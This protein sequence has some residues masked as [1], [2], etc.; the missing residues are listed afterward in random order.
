MLIGLL[1]LLSSLGAHAA[2][3]WTATC[4]TRDDPSVW[5]V[6]AAAPLPP[7]APPLASDFDCMGLFFD[8]TVACP[9]TVGLGKI[10]PGDTSPGG[11]PLLELRYLP[12]GDS[13]GI[14]R[15]LS[16]PQGGVLYKLPTIAAPTSYAATPPPSTASQL[17]ELYLNQRN[18]A[19]AATNN[20]AL[21]VWTC[22]D[23]KFVPPVAAIEPYGMKLVQHQGRVSMY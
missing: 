1:A 13:A 21:H 3:S 20:V 23:A 7:E 6:F 17:L 18:K 16:Q 10:R 14:V 4:P 12:Y 15:F 19:S 2:D 22:P 5:F 9:Q 8:S 11:I